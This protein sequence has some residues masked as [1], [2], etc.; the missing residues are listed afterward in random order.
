MVGQDPEPGVGPLVL[1]VGVPGQGLGRLDHRSEQVG[2]EDRV[3][4]LEHGQDPLEAGPGV[5]ARPGQGLDGPVDRAVGLHE[6]QVPDLD[7][8]LLPAECRPAVLPVAGALV[9]EQLRAR[10]P[11]TGLPHVPEVVLPQALDAVGRHAHRVTPDLLG[12]VVALVD[13]DPQPVAVDAEDL[14]HQ[15][16]GE[17]DGLGLEVVAEAEVAQHLEER[18]VPVGGADDVDVVG[19]ETF[20]HRGGPGPGRDLVARG[21][22]A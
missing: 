10:P 17:G 1:P 22:T 5:D 19:A 14:G 20:L 9:E 11:R 16:P 21:R 4:P 2:G 13:G 7:E 8:P 3:D 15:L 18:A 12:F 6:D